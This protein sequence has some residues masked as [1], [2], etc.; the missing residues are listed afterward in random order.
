[1]ANT[2]TSIYLDGTGDYIETG[3]SLAS[4]NGPFTFEG[5]FYPTDADRREGLFGS[6]TNDDF[7][8]EFQADNDLMVFGRRSNGTDYAVNIVIDDAD[9]GSKTVWQHIAVC[10]IGI[11]AAVYK[12]GVLKYFGHNG[13]GYNGHPSG[14]ANIRLGIY[15]TLP[16][17]GYID[18]ARISKVSRYGNIDLPVT[19]PKTWQTAGRG[20]NALLPQ[21][22]KVLITAEDVADSGVNIIDRSSYG[23]TVTIDSITGSTTSSILA[24]APHS[25][26]SVFYQD[27]TD[28]SSLRMTGGT[29]ADLGGDWSAEGWFYPTQASGVETLMSGRDYAWGLRGNSRDGTDY[30]GLTIGAGSSASPGWSSPDPFI[31]CTSENVL[32]TSRWT[33]VA[34]GYAG[35]SYFIFMNGVLA[36]SK[37]VA[38]QYLLASNE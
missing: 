10:R 34:C 15:A 35:G 33:H 12:N 23:H 8:I 9:W 37:T 19:R 3:V 16:F 24:A 14:M 26:T 30:L 18:S 25:P 32:R 17:K 21:H 13:A 31:A 7:D 6:G 1:M 29:L 5:W 11:N 36:A 28:S 4:Y 22:T 38:N 20:Q 27:G 2:A